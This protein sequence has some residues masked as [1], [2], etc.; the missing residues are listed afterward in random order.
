MRVFHM[1]DQILKLAGIQPEE[2]RRSLDRLESL[3]KNK[4]NAGQVGRYAALGAAAGPALGVVRNVIEGGKKW[5]DF[6]GH[7][8]RGALAAAATGAIASGAVP[9]VREELDRKAELHK[10]K[11]FMREN[12]PPTKMASKMKRVVRSAARTVADVPDFQRGNIT[13]VVMGKASDYSK[14]EKK[15]SVEYFFETLHTIKGA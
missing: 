6:G 7:P 1:V 13:G 4:P 15:A 5:H 12:S 2:A 9:L 3:D 14:S 10:L 8:V 11:T